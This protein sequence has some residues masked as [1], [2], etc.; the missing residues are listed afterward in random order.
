MVHSIYMNIFKRIFQAVKAFLQKSA[1]AG[2]IE[3]PETLP[4][5][6]KFS[7]EQPASVNNG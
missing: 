4:P 5:A 7:N 2:S 1:G 6:P 3:T